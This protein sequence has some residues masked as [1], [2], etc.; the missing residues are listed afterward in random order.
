MKNKSTNNQIYLSGGG[1]E[2][3]SFLLDKFFFSRIPKGGKFLY[4][5]VALRG[6]KKWKWGQP[7]FITIYDTIYACQ[8]LKG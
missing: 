3:Q 5:P 4:I 7:P 8:E 2:T 6:H 1:D